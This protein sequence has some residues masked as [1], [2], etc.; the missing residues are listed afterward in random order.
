[1]DIVSL[2]HNEDV[3][4]V[5]SLGTTVC[6]AVMERSSH[7]KARVL[8]FQTSIDCLEKEG[9]A[10]LG[11]KGVLVAAK[12]LSDET[13]SENRLAAL[14]LLEVVLSKMS[15]DMQRLVRICGPNLSEKARHLLEERRN[16]KEADSRPTTT[17]PNNEASHLRMSESP[18]DH[19][20]SFSLRDTNREDPVASGHQP[21]SQTTK[22]NRSTGGAAD[23]RARLLKI[24]EKSTAYE[25][26]E[27]TVNQGSF[28]DEDIV[29]SPQRD[30]EEEV[31]S[32]GIA[33]LNEILSAE[34]PLN[35]EDM[36][37]SESIETLKRFH[38]ALSKQQHPSAGL[39]VIELINLRDIITANLNTTI[40][41]LTQ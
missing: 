14:D 32:R 29:E 6:V 25:P 21:D 16:E 10:A 28:V 5:K 13:V 1:M 26:M 23:L 38:A 34:P 11:K 3:L 24:R 12:S 22:Q 37:L 19:L 36:R 2:A 9:L 7:A 18:R 30:N 41:S 4:S 8:C 33:C 15:G 35:E 40:E 39:Q 27:E 20:P 31:F 17:S